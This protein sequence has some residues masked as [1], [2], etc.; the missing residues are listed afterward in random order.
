MKPWF[1]T[2]YNCDAI[3]SKVDSKLF[4]SINSYCVS[5]F[6]SILLIFYE[7]VSN[8]KTCIFL[9][10]IFLKGLFIWG[11]LLLKISTLSIFNV[12]KYL[13]FVSIEYYYVNIFSLS[14]ILNIFHNKFLTMFN[15]CFKWLCVYLCVDSE[16]FISTHNLN[17]MLIN[18]FII[19]ESNYC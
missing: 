16:Y 13:N 1:Y 10:A 17:N 5:Q 4:L 7:R 12:N 9:L 19:L 6:S 3:K 2:S 14:I 11:K 8:V 15:N 18:L